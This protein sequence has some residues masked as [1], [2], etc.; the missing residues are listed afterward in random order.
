MPCRNDIESKS[1]IGPPRS[2]T[3]LQRSATL[4]A[5]PKF[6]K[7]RVPFR[8]RSPSTDQVIARFLN[9]LSGRIN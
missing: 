5:N 9:G 4:P 2:G 8:V 3:A 6:A 7:G 1:P